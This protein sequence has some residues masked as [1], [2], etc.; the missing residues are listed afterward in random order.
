M[1]VISSVELAHR[2]ADELIATRKV[3][4]A[5]VWLSEEQFVIPAAEAPEGYF[6]GHGLSSE[7]ARDL[8]FSVSPLRFERG[9]PL[10]VSDLRYGYV[11]IPNAESLQP[12]TRKLL[13]RRIRAAAVAMSTASTLARAESEGR[14]LVL[15]I[16]DDDALRTLLR[17]L[18][19]RERFHVI[20]A[21]NGREG[22]DVA[23]REQPDLVLMDWIMPVMDGEEATV[24]LR[25]ARATAQIPV[26]MLTHRSRAQDK[27]EALHAGVQDF[28]PKPFDFR[29]LVQI[30]DTQLRWRRLLSH[31]GESAIFAAEPPTAREPRGAMLDQLVRLVRTGEPEAALERAIA[32]AE[33]YEEQRAHDRAGAAYK[34]AADAAEALDRDD[35]AKRLLRL[36]GRAYLHWAQTATKSEDCQRGYTLSVRRF[37]EAGNLKLAGETEEAPD[38]E[39]SLVPARGD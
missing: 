8:I 1:S 5:R 11:E 17:K 13:E 16:D 34:I 2:L 28:V 9:F 6:D 7:E 39:R 12:D 4:A 26:V 20:E 29:T 19:E 27:L 30:I 15:I 23:T 18:L 31:G 32:E 35:L 10:G 14:G 22:I 25:H 33:R 3:E 38:M 21:S 36:S 37:M 24:G